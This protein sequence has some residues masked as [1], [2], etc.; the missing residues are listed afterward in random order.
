[1][2]QT[3]TL[4]QGIIT[5]EESSPSSLQLFIG[6]ER[7]IKFQENQE[8]GENNAKRYMGLAQLVQELERNLEI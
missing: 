3:T 4:Q 6:I 8:I 1:M 2:S 7:T 5:T